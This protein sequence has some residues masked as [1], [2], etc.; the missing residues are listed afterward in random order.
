[1]FD[2]LQGR[3]SLS[4]SLNVYISRRRFPILAAFD[5]DS[6]ESLRFSEHDEM[7]YIPD[8]HMAFP[9]SK[10][11]AGLFYI[12]PKNMRRILFGVQRK[13]T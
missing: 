7:I 11:T 12:R 1:M 10:M 13:S 8:Y 4:P 9:E 3:F 6:D 5:D 2:V